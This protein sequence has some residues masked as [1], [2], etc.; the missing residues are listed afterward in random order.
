MAGVD[1]DRVEVV[2]VEGEVAEV[3][4]AVEVELAEVEVEETYVETAGQALPP[5]GSPSLSVILDAVSTS[6][7][8]LGITT[9]PCGVV[10]PLPMLATNMS[11]NPERPSP[12]VPVIVTA[13]QSIYISG[14][15]LVWANQVQAKIT[16]PDVVSFGTV[17]ENDFLGTGQPP[18][19]VLI[20]LKVT[21]S[22]SEID[23]WQEPPS[24]GDVPSIMKVCVEPACHDSTESPS[25]VLNSLTEPLHGKLLPSGSSGD[26]MS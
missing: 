2:G 18:I 12:P 22:S 7:P 11:G 19:N 16:F 13:A 6:P 3:E 5:I 8:G 9:S 10:Q 17:K 14:V 1:P 23:A 21:P 25:G 26:L 4:E 24:W 20:A 15:A